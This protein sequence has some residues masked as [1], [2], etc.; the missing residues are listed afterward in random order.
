M[1]KNRPNPLDDH[2]KAVALR[3]QFRS[4]KDFKRHLKKCS[5]NDEEIAAMWKFA[6][7]Y[8]IA[9]KDGILPQEGQ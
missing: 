3:N 6:K 1:M 8:G 2:A 4:E 7:R 5:W 9:T